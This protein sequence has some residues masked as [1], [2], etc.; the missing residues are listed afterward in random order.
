MMD[1]RTFL[2]AAAATVATIG[3][4][5]LPVIAKPKLKWISLSE[6]MPKYRQRILQVSPWTFRSSW[7]NRLISIQ[8]II[9]VGKRSS[10]STFADVHSHL[11]LEME[12]A[13]TMDTHSWDRHNVL[14]H[15]E[16]FS[17]KTKI[18]VCKELDEIEWI[19]YKEVREGNWGGIASLVAHDEHYWM[20]IGDKI[21]VN[22]PLL[23]KKWRYT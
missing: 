20:P 8:H 6:Q 3:I 16:N 5:I 23:P 4:P 17:K 2:K 21:P 11:G 12:F 15:Y 1:R 13:I 18:E 7:D 19:K 9:R 14:Y 10:L 22:I